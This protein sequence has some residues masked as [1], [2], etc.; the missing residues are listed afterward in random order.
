M[1]IVNISFLLKK[2]KKE[3]QWQH[4]EKNICK[5]FGDKQNSNIK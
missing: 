1:D 5:D 3:K 4:L 2:K